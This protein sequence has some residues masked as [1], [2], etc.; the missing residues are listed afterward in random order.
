MKRAV[1]AGTF[2]VLASIADADEVVL[3]SG[4]RLQGEIVERTESFILIET[5]PGRVRVSMD[6][7][8]RVSTGGSALAEY[9]R[10]ASALGSGDATGWLSLARWATERDLKTQAKVA[11]ERVVAVD[12]SN[13]E[14]QNALG[15]V[16]YRGQWMTPEDSYRAQGLVAF[17]GR[18]VTPAEMDA[19]LREREIER[20]ARTRAAEAA[21]RRDEAEA[22]AREAEA[23]ARAAESSAGFWPAYGVGVVAP[24]AVQPCCGH[25][26]APGACP[27]APH[28]VVRAPM[29]PPQPQRAPTPM[30]DGGR[31]RLSGASEKSAPSSSRGHAIPRPR[32]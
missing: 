29:A 28:V 6:R 9:R 11:F 25:A 7:V 10:R 27:F 26:H 14:A 3:K 31:A 22:L 5:G 18:W 4:G 20:E 8:E 16:S 30:R 21:A 24:W 32:P 23:R 17:G 12:P 19:Q 13:A 2:V 1:L 15:R